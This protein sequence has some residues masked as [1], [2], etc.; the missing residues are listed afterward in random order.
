MDRAEAVMKEL[1]IW[2][3]GETFSQCRKRNRKHEEVEKRLGQVLRAR[4]RW[5]RKTAALPSVPLN[6]M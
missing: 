2:E 6:V 1:G 5:R 4:R 3:E